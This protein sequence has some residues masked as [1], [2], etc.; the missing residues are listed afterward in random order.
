MSELGGT[1]AAPVLN[2][3]DVQL[4]SFPY[5]PY[6]SDVFQLIL[7][8]LA[9]VIM[10]SFI[11]PVTMMCKDLVLEKERKL[12]V[13]TAFRARLLVLNLLMNESCDLRLKSYIRVSACWFATNRIIVAVL[14]VSHYNLRG[15]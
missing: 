12:K 9:I 7:T 11:M 3:M 6:Y 4:K 10:F 13:G 5:P 8:F 2:K 14:Y 1:S 15:Y